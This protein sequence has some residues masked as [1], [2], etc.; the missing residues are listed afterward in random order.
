MLYEQRFFFLFFSFFFFL[1]KIGRT[2]SKVN[3]WYKKAIVSFIVLAFSIAD[4]VSKIGRY[5]NSLITD[6]L[7]YFRPLVRRSERNNGKW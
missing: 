3:N 7:A 6:C 1:T 4:F 5:F 2:P